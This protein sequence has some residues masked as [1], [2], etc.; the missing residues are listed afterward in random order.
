MRPRTQAPSALLVL[1]LLLSPGIG[2]AEPITLKDWLSVK[3]VSGLDLSPDGRLA[4]F[5]LS[6]FN[7]GKNK[8]ES[9]LWLVR[10]D[11]RAAPRQLTAAAGTNSAPAFSP[12]GKR[13]AFISTRGGEPQVWLIAVDF[14]EAT[15]LTHLAGGAS[16]PLVWTPDGKAVAFAS[17]VYPDCK[18]EACNARRLKATE[19]SKV[20]ARVF[21]ALLYR[22]WNDW[23]DERR[24]HLLLQPVLGGAPRDLTPGRFDVPPIDLGG[25]PD[26]DFSPDGKNL[27]YTSNTDLMLATSTNNDVFEVA[28]AGGK[29]RRLTE[30]KGNDYNPRYSPDGRRLA[31]LSMARPGFEADRPRVMV[32][33]RA[34]G[35]EIEWSRGWDG[36]PLGLSWAPDGRRLLFIAPDRGQEEIFA[37]NEGGVRRLSQGLFGRD[38]RASRDGK[39]LLVIDEATERAPEVVALSAEAKD[40]R[41]LTRF[42]EWLTRKYRLRP[43]EHVW[44]PGAGGKSIHAVLV[45]PPGARPGQ[46]LPAM[47]MVHGGPQGMT[48]ADFHP[49]WNLSMFASAGY[50]VLGVN[51]HGSLGYGQAFTDAISGDWGGKPFEDV[52]KG[53][54]WLAKQPFADGKRICAA[55]ASYGGYLVNWMATRTDRFKCFISHAGVYNLESKYG[56]TEELWFP[57]WEFRGTPWTNRAL[58]RKLSPHSYAEKLRTPMLVIHGQR[59]YRVPVEQGMQL[60]TALQRQQVPSRFLYFPDEDHFVQKPQNIELWWNTMRDWLGRYLGR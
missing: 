29:P 42:N 52:M 37:A 41:P 5:A 26:F 51:F 60:F 55:G 15:E 1:A 38:L 50:L 59:D 16:G 36:H 33:D 6:R 25:S 48:G 31:Y 58:Y 47:I 10:S 44:F 4:A 2:R 14:G 17:Q 45:R 12:D 20:K 8:R 19:E 22:H 23:R 13:L 35:K 54:D 39:R 7:V 28:V 3:W 18:D 43:A 24:S 40:R 27:A 53:V 11:G 46:K 30:G 21:D 9:D 34:S 57:E 32:R 49:R 56:S